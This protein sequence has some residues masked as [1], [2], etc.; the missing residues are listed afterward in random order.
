MTSEDGND[1]PPALVMHWCDDVRREFFGKHTIVGLYSNVMALPAP[2]V[3]LA[4]LCAVFMMDL[5]RSAADD[6][7]EVLLLD[8]GEVLAELK[9]HTA[10]GQQRPPHPA[11]EARDYVVHAIELAGFEVADGMQLHGAVRLKGVDIFRSRPLMVVS[12]QAPSPE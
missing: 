10:Q 8:R 11:F 9:L 7:L 3:T 1:Y 2:K 5:P 12:L 6:A 4:K